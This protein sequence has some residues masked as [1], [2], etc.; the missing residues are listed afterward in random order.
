[1]TSA[2]LVA[3]PGS[4][5]KAKGTS[6]GSRAVARFRQH[7]LA[8]FG[9]VAGYFWAAP[10]SLLRDGPESGPD[11]FRGGGRPTGVTEESG[12]GGWPAAER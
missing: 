8:V 12:A 4:R 7:R 2:A 5:R 9:L 3:P 6:P 1:M 10:V 11:T